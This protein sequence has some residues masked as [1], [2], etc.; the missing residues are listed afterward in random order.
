[1]SV[2]PMRREMK[3]RKGK[4]RYGKSFCENDENCA[5]ELLIKSFDI[6]DAFHVLDLKAK[7]KFLTDL[8]DSNLN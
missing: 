2:F 3:F 1:M 7:F 5:D 8:Q 4:K 6:K